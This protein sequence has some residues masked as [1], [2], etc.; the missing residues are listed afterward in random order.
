MQDDIL[1]II[2]PLPKIETIRCKTIVAVITFFLRFSTVIASLVAWYLY[3]YFIAGGTLL[4]SFL[5]VG[6]IRSKLR[7]DAVP[8]AQREYAYTDKAIATWYA[9]KRICF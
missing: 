1:E 4:V 8:P 6:I 2:E 5:I 3:D 7:N 9:A